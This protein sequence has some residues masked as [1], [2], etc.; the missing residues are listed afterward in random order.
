MRDFKCDNICSY[1]CVHL[2]VQA[3]RDSCSSYMNVRIFWVVP[4]IIYFQ[5]YHLKQS[6]PQVRLFELMLVQTGK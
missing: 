3:W 6:Y 5:P 2:G 4:F 1:L